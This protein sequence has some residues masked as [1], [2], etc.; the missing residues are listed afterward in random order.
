MFTHAYTHTQSHQYVHKIN[1][2]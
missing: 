2:Q 1:K